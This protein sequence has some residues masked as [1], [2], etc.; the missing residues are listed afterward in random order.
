MIKQGLVKPIG[1]VYYWCN[2]KCYIEE[3]LNDSYDCRCS[4]QSLTDGN[5]MER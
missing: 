2:E 1:I 5:C 3:A 4:M